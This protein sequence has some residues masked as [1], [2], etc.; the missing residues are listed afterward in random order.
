MP[1]AAWS[2][3]KAIRKP[4]TSGPA[5]QA[6]FRSAGSDRSGHGFESIAKVSHQVTVA[7]HAARLERPDRIIFDLDPGE[8]VAWKRVQEAAQLLHAL[9]AEL[10]LQGLLK[11]S[12]GKGLHITVPFAP[13]HDWDTASALAKAITTHLA[14]TMPDRFASK[15]GPRNRVGKIFADYL[16]NKRGATTAAPWS[17]RARPGIGIS[18]PNT[19][20]EL[21]D[22]EGGDHWT[23][24]TVEERLQLGDVAAAAPKIAQQSL[25]TFELDR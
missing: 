4:S 19:W 25:R 18:V 24:R 14:M 16:R 15:S 10:D 12:G 7:A 1:N 20:D 23:L 22:V 3:R 17:A 13:R 2:V 6:A 11:T 5:R 9:L 21:A 8:G